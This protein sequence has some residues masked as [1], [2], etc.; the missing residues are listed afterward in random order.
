MKLGGGEVGNSL[1]SPWGEGPPEGGN[2]WTILKTWAF[3]NEMATRKKIVK[4]SEIM[5]VLN[6]KP[7]NT[8]LMFILLNN[9]G[10]SHLNIFLSANT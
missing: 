1:K 6:I 8:L 2:V 3:T 7:P 4:R 9:L 10:F 5:L